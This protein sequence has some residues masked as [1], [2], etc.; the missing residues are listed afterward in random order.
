[1]EDAEGAELRPEECAWK[2]GR[3]ARGRRGARLG[4]CGACARGGEC[5]RGGERG[6]EGWE[7]NCYSGK[8][9]SFTPILR[10]P[11]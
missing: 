1:M 9:A 10:S 2:A 8:Y 5:G 3:S 6:E 7:S 4:G 11:N